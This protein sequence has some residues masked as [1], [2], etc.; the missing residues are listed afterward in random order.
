MEEQHAKELVEPTLCDFKL[1]GS[2]LKG[3]GY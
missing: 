1:Q 3:H 2:E